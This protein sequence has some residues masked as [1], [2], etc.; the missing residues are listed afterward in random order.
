VTGAKKSCSSN[1]LQKQE[2]SKAK[3]SKVEPEK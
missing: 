2:A 3:K 1:L